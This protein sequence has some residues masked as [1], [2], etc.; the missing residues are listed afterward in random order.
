MSSTPST[1]TP[2]M[3]IANA[4]RIST[5]MRSPTEIVSEAGIPRASRTAAK[6]TGSG[7]ERPV[8]SRPTTIGTRSRTPRAARLR[9]PTER[10]LLVRQAR[11]RPLESSSSAF[12]RRGS[13]ER[14]SSGLMSSSLHRMLVSMGTPSWRNALPSEVLPPPRDAAHSRSA[15]FTRRIAS[16]TDHDRSRARRSTRTRTC[17]SAYP[18]WL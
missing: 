12:L 18:G 10:G 14:L 5:S 3:P 9:S 8:A 13:G 7:L 16:S 11:D 4:G 17:D 1:R 2:P 15:S 6:G